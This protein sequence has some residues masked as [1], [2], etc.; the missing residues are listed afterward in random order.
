MPSTIT[1]PR[2][3]RVG[4]VRYETVVKGNRAHVAF[5]CGH[6]HHQWDVVDEGAEPPPA[7]KPKKPAR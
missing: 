5:V 4:F 1:C 2:C 7:K 3:H 6:C